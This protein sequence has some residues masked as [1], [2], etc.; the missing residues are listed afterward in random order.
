MTGQLLVVIVK[1]LLQEKEL[2]KKKQNALK[3]LTKITWD[4]VKIASLWKLL[5][6]SRSSIWWAEGRFMNVFNEKCLNLMILTGRWRSSLN[7]DSSEF[8]ERNLCKHLRIL[9]NVERKRVAFPSA[10]IIMAWN[11][12][13]HQSYQSVYRSIGS[14]SCICQSSQ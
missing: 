8:R 10:T 13:I 2:D 3:F 14:I 5:C 7:T 6:K 11:L 4:R 9:Y 12:N 1:G